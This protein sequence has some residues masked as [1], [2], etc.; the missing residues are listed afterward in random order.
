MMKHILSIFLILSVTASKG[1]VQLISATELCTMMSGFSSDEEAHSVLNELLAVVHWEKNFVMAP[2]SGVDNACAVNV[3]GVRYILYNPSFMESMDN[4]AGDVA[5]YFI[6]AHEMAHHILLHTK[7]LLLIDPSLANQIELAEKR[8]QEL[9][10]DEYAA[11]VLAALGYSL[12]EIKLALKSLDSDWRSAKVEDEIYSTHP[13][14]GKRLFAVNKGYYQVIDKQEGHDAM[15]LYL[16]GGEAFNQQDYY[17]ALRHFEAS[18]EIADV[19]ITWQSLGQTHLQLENYEKALACFSIALE[20]GLDY[21][22]LYDKGVSLWY[23]NRK[24]EAC[25][26]WKKCYINDNEYTYYVDFCN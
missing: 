12:G 20:Y 14:I 11:M 18:L 5:G 3:N 13:I 19:S 15:S 4:N 26:C 10:A 16:K 1:Q 2:C 22:I 25:D 8:K 6:L 21:D 24:P 23:L 17:S 7:D 9:E